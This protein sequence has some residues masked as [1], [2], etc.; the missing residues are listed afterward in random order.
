ME[1]KFDADEVKEL[2]IAKAVSLGIQANSVTFDS[3]YSTVRSA[4]VFYQAPIEVKDEA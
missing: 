4:T 1:L 2:L 3:G